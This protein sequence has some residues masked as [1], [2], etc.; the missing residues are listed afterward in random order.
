MIARTTENGNI[1]LKAESGAEGMLLK[2][3]E[4]NNI[5]VWHQSRRV[6]YE[7]GGCPRYLTVV[8]LEITDV[9]TKR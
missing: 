5:V 8:T 6:E 4:S 1:V 3:M 7:E 9:N 2:K